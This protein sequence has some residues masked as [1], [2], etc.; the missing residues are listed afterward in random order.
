MLS[1]LFAAALVGPP[2]YLTDLVGTPIEAAGS[3][4]EIL[5]RGRACLAQQLA[6]GQ[7]GGQVVVSD[8]PAAGVIVANNADSY[9]ERFVTWRVRSRVTFEAKDGRFRISHSG[10]E[11][12]NNTWSPIGK[13]R[14]SGWERAEQAFK[15]RSDA[16]ATCV[17]SAPSGD[18]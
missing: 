18:W 15:D 4:A 1:I 17:K 11:R 16:L 12:F 3:A 2:E 7:A 14:G 5:S 8:D 10:L 13:W 6:S 9:T